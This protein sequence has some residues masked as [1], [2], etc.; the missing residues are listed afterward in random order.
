[1][2]MIYFWEDV[3]KLN[4]CYSIYTNLIDGASGESNVTNL[5][6]NYFCNILDA[7]TC[8]SDLKNEIMVQLKNIHHTDG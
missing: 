1:M 6:K 4:S 5:R 2:I 8:D 7:S 3:R